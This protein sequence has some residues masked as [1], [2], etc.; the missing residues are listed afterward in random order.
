MKTVTEH[1]KKA[2][3]WEREL[4]ANDGKCPY[5]HAGRNFYDWPMDGG[6]AVRV[7]VCAVC[8]PAIPGDNANVDMQA[9]YGPVKD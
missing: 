2:R 3:P 7:V 6:H 1:E 5:G 9:V 4:A 8:R